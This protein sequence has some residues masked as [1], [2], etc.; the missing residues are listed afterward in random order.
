MSAYQKRQCSNAIKNYSP[1][2]IYSDINIEDI[3]DVN[4]V[5]N[6]TDYNEKIISD[7]N[8]NNSDTHLKNKS[9]KLTKSKPIPIIGP[10]KREYSVSRE[11]PPN[12]FPNN[13]NVCLDDIVWGLNKISPSNFSN[14]SLDDRYCV[15]CSL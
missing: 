10:N 1:S 3:I 8:D 6:I 4:D 11:Y 15:S 5:K 13:E 9:S 7:N 2:K 14:Y 12:H